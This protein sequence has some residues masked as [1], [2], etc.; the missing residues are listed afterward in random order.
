[1]EASRHL[2]SER[3]ATVKWD[4]MRTSEAVWGSSLDNGSHMA[5]IEYQVPCVSPAKEGFI[6]RGRLP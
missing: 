6:R 1:M 2:C 5:N 3:K 4:E